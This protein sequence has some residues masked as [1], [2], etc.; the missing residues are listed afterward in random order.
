MSTIAF[1]GG[2][3]LLSLFLAMHNH[4]T[5]KLRGLLCQ[6][7]NSAIGLLGENPKLFAAALAYMEKH[8]G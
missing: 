8:R 6:A 4:S 1:L 7:C 2:L 3:L 5:G